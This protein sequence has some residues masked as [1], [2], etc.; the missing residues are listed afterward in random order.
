MAVFISYAK[1]GI[2]IKSVQNSVTVEWLVAAC[3]TE[4]NVLRHSFLDNVSTSCSYILQ[5]YHVM[6]NRDDFD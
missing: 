5:D 4:L 3:S 2:V 1:Y 6:H